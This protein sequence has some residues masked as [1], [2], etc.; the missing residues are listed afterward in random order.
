M[1][2]NGESDRTGE[3]VEILR[4]IWNEMKALNSRTDRVRT[5]L[6]G[7]ISSLRT[8]LKAEISSLRTELKAEVAVLREETR[9][10][11]ATLDHRL[12]NLLLGD[13][14]N[15]HREFRKRFERIEEHLGLP[16]PDGVP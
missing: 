9:K 8:E 2:T 13:H 1:S 15:E 3:M 16:P 11:F 4:N 10:G 12:D 7:E 6:K 5:E 14:G